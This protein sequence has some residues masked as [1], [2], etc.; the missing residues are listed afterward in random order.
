MCSGEHGENAESN[1][2][3][4]PTSDPELICRRYERQIYSVIRRFVV[5]PQDADDVFQ[6]VVLKVLKSKDELKNL[7]RIEAWIRTVARN[8]VMDYF[9]RRSNE[10][11]LTGQV[12]E[13][14]LNKK[15]DNVGI[16]H[17]YRA[18]P[19]TMTGELKM[20][21]ERILEVIEG[22]LSEP[23]RLRYI[24]GKKWKE[25]CAELGISEKTARKRCEK[26]RELVL[27]SLEIGQKGDSSQ[28]DM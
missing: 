2:S 8:T 9:R 5:A 25:I 26:A 13:P 16:P 6:E 22:K 3:D 17:V 28:Y 4:N 14:L 10:R 11:K 7:F 1:V 18:E 23:F 24:E 27:G 19:E 21:V 20:E 12:K 15:E